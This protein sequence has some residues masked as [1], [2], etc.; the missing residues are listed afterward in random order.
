MDATIRQVGPVAV[1]DRNGIYGESSGKFLR[2]CYSVILYRRPPQTSN[3]ND[4]IER[5]NKA[6]QEKL[7]DHR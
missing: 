2:D 3:C 1:S 5:W 7:L 4:F 6:L